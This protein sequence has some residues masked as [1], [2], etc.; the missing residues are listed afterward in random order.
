MDSVEKLAR[1]REIAMT[2][3]EPKNAGEIATVAD[4][5]RNTAAKYLTQLAEDNVLIAETRGRETIYRPDPVTQYF[6]QLRK[7]T[8]EHTKDELTHELDAIRTDIE[9][10]SSRY[11]VDH[12]DELR[13]TVGDASGAEERAQR[14]QDAEDW[15][16]FEHQRQLIQ[17]ALELYD[18]VVESRRTARA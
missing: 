10:F 5:S 4:V 17:Q 16:Y 15:E 6:S 8:S 12:P 1:I 7:L 3:S 18:G 2:V 11:G 14:R 9:R 13:A